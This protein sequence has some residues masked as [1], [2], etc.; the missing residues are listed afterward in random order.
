MATATGA[1]QTWAEAGNMQKITFKK[2]L[3]DYIFFWENYAPKMCVTDHEKIIVMEI[4]KFLKEKHFNGG[5]S[6]D[7]IR[8]FS[9]WKGLYVETIKRNG[10]N[11]PLI[12]AASSTFNTLINRLIKEY[13]DVAIIQN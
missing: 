7:L 1:V 8:T 3:E 5:V 11:Q 6:L 9:Y 4:V 2:Q 10:N 12:R 13:A